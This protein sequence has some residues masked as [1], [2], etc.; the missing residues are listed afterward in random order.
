MSTVS[1][2]DQQD[3]RV[4][5]IKD[6]IRTIPHWPKEG[7]MFRDITTFLQ[8]PESFKN[9]IDILYERYKDMKIDAVAGLESRG[10]ILGA[11]LAYKLGVSFVCIRKPNKLP[12]KTIKATYMK[13]YGPDV[14]EMHDDA[15]SKGYVVYTTFFL[16]KK[17]SNL[18][19]RFLHFTANVFSWLTI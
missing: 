13:E 12:S 11:P 14:L 1:L 10:F 4:T 15:I 18:L 6:H 8:H 3:P 17:K 16:K 7:I 19:A 9:S 5:T 2:H